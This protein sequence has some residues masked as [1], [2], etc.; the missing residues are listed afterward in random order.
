MR[1]TLMT[2]CMSLATISA[3]A[4]DVTYEVSGMMPDSIKKVYIYSLETEVNN[5]AVAFDYNCVD[6]ADVAGGRF[7]MKGKCSKLSYYQV[8]VPRTSIGQP[9]FFDGTPIHIDFINNELKGSADNEKLFQL[10]KVVYENNEKWFATIKDFSKYADDKAKKDSL[11]AERD[12]II[13]EKNAYCMKCYTE[14]KNSII[15]LSFLRDISYELSDEELADAVSPSRMYY[16]HPLLEEAKKELTKREE[17]KALRHVGEMFIDVK[18]ND[19][20]MKSHKLSEWVG[21]GKYVLIDF[22]AS[23]CGP[24]RAEMPNVLENY[25]K[26]KDKGFEV[27]GISLDTKSDAWVSGIKKLD[28]PFPQLSELSGWKGEYHKKYGIKTIPANL[29]IGP[30]GRIIACD[31]RAAKLSSTLEKIFENK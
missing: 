18:M 25:N 14:N 31:L 19:P 24:C 28:I 7:I 16:G 20:Q 13:R 30:N 29:L 23:W 21:K 2:F 12:K 1:K 6:S 5:K 9:V 4:Q 26:Y 3:N 15:G 17:I 27:V 8:G 11:L 22:W 10:K